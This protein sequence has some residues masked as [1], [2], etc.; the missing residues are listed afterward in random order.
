MDDRLRTIRR[1]LIRSTLLD[2]FLTPA[3]FWLCGRHDA[4]CRANAAGR[5]VGGQSAPIRTAP[6]WATPGCGRIAL[7]PRN[8]AVT[9]RADTADVSCPVSLLKESGCR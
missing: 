9:G 8:R 1:P 2:T 3:V 6:A 4:E 5:L 7:R